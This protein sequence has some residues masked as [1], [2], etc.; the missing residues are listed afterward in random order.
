M[1]SLSSRS[2]EKELNH[3]HPPNVNS[4]PTPIMADQPKKAKRVSPQDAIDEFWTMFSAND[5]TAGKG[6]LYSVLIPDVASLR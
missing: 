3:Q 2:L 5:K 6:E 1:A 4:I